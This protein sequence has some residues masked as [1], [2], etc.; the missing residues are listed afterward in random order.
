MLEQVALFGET[1]ADE[2]EER[3]HASRA[4]NAVATDYPD[5]LGAFLVRHDAHLL[6]LA[7]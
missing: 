3:T 2:I 4:H 6:E 1:L 7:A 5:R